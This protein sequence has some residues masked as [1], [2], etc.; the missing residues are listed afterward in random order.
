M[1]RLQEPIAVTEYLVPLVFVTSNVPDAA[2]T[3]RA[4][5]AASDDYVMPFAGSVVG[6][7]V[8]HNADLTGGIIT[9]N[10]VVNDV[11]KTAISAVTNDTNQQAVKTV[12]ADLVPFAAGDR[13]GC[14][15]TKSGTVA[16]TTTDVVVIVWVL[17]IGVK[18]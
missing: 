8:R 12:D 1:T 3:A 13:I 9:W 11:A 15:W 14:E 18:V 10:P 7:T 4:V 2:G 6:L 17:L 5:E 16:P